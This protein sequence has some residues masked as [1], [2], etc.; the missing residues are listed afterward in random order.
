LSSLPQQ[1][2]A[3]KITE[4]TQ[5]L[6]FGAVPIAIVMI[7]VMKMP[8]CL[9]DVPNLNLLD[10]RAAE[11]T[12]SMPVT[13][14]KKTL[15]QFGAV[16]VA[17]VMISVMKMPP[18]LPDVPNL[19]LL[20]LVSAAEVTRSLPV[21][22]QETALLQFGAVPVAIVMISVMKMP[23][24]LPDVPN[25]NLL[26]LVRAAEV[27]RSMPVTPQETALLQ[28]GAV[29]IAI[30]LISVMKMPPFLPDVPNLNLLD[31]VGAAEVTRSMAVTPQATA[32]LQFG[33]VPIAIVM[34]SVMKMPPFLLGVS[35]VLVILLLLAHLLPFL[36]KLVFH[37]SRNLSRL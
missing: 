8:P 9:P 22:P 7:S 5:L 18:C 13:P 31:L 6:Q 33:A 27:T 3:A 12:R 21:T 26:D 19:N 28:I 23:P 25:L 36:K 20:D 11:V 17:I 14:Q 32:S 29:P 37:L 35:T 30:V 34:I 15:L 24:F 1:L 10:L 2:R 4:P 16:P